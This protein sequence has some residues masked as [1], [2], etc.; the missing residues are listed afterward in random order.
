MIDYFSRYIE[1]SLCWERRL[2]KQWFINWRLSSL[3]RCSGGRYGWQ[4]TP[5]TRCHHLQFEHV[6]SNPRFPQSNREAE[7][8]VKIIKNLPDKVRDRYLSVSVDNTRDGIFAITATDGMPTAFD[9]PI[10]SR[11]HPNSQTSKNFMTMKSNTESDRARSTTSVTG[12]QL[13][14]NIIKERM[15]GIESWCSL[16]PSSVWEGHHTHTLPPHQGVYS[17]ETTA[18]WLRASWWRG[19]WD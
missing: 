7:R 10:T 17:D 9:T 15:S 5:I 18:E 12:S 19:T 2:Q 3:D 6:T 11:C 8:V 13:Y 4:W 14:Q 1:K 16:Q